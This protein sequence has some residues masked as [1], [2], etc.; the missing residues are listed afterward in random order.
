MHI[1]L[2][3]LFIG[4]YQKLDQFNQL[5]RKTLHR[6]FK[7]SQPP[8]MQI[9]TQKFFIYCCFN[10]REITEGIFH[11]DSYASKILLNRLFLL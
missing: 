1:R 2:S 10:F 4:D 3:N 6:H 8:H 7:Y 11:T 9:C 5:N